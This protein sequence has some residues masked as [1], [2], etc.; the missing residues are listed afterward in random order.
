MTVTAPHARICQELEFFHSAIAE[1]LS[2]ERG[3][4]DRTGRLSPRRSGA[5]VRW[6]RDPSSGF[7][8]VVNVRIELQR[9]SLSHRYSPRETI[10]LPAEVFGRLLPANRPAA[11][12]KNCW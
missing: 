5:I 4:P 8:H 7:S 9:A 2:D 12:E 10:E 11:F 1:W 6:S 3:Q